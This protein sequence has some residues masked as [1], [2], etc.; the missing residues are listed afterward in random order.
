MFAEDFCHAATMTTRGQRFAQVLLAR[1]EELDIVGD[2]EI[3]RAGGVSDSTMTKVRKA[4]RGEAD[5]APPRNPAFKKYDL[6][7]RWEPGSARRLWLHD[8]DPVP[9]REATAPRSYVSVED[10]I[11]AANITE[12][13][14]E[15]LLEMLR[16]ETPP[17]PPT[18]PTPETEPESK[19]GS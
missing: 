1:Y 3:G 6:S 15:I 17:T 16:R 14:R 18:P 5:M 10:E 8:M 2:D 9:V 13:A 11:K 7:A 12:G 4:A 19:T